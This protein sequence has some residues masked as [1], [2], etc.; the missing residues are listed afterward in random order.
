LPNPQDACLGDFFWQM[1]KTFYK[2]LGEKEQWPNI[3]GINP[4]SLTYDDVLLV[5][6]ISQIKSRSEVDTTVQFG[7]FTL[8]KP[9]IAAPM[10]T[11][12]GEDMIRELHRLGA[13]GI[14]PRGDIDQ[15]KKLCQE[16]SGENINCVYAVGL[17]NGFEEAKLLK[18]N[19]AKMILL[20]VAH[21]GMVEVVKVAKKIKEE[22]SLAII[23]GN[24]VTY[25]EAIIYKKD[26]VDVARVGVGPGGLCITRLVA[27]SGFPQLSAVFET[28]SAN[29]PVIA[30]GGVKKPG[31]F[32]K[33]IAAGATIVMIGSLFAGADEAP[34]E[35]VDGYKVA[36]GQ[37]SHAYMKDNGVE[38]GEFRSAEGVSIKVPV[39]G[40]VKHLVHD[41]MGGLRSAMTYAGAVNIQEFQKKA[42]FC[43]VSPATLEENIPWLSKIAAK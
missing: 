27:G 43:K 20:D 31:D 42:V 37:A 30:D 40:P 2:A 36:R 35:L 14:L 23:A 4:A 29:I 21:G 1:S 9:I 11:I 3:T 12:C 6:Q 33:A 17:K 41:L 22:L 24:I 18:E 34:G 8:T 32:A 26:S 7:P 39:K 25:E 16:F 5:P 10:D 13:I 15:R 19:G 28:T 38:A